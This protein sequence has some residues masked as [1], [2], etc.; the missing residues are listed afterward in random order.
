M[1]HPTRTPAHEL[2]V[3]GTAR[4]N[5]QTIGHRSVI[6]VTG[7]VD[8]LAAPSL[9]RAIDEALSTGC[10]E[11]WID[12]TETEFMDSSGLHALVDTHARV[13]DLERRLTV[14]CPPGPVRRVIDVSGLADQ[15]PLAVDRAAAHRDS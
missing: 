7:E 15:L 11:L 10:L 2:F 4:F 3:D 5:R 12:L 14:I 6:G 13:R 9:R 8:V 1:D